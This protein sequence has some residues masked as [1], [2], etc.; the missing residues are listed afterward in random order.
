MRDNAQTVLNADAQHNTVLSIHMYDVFSTPASITDYL[1][2]FQASGWPLV[3]GEFGW[4][5]SPSNVNHEAVLS[6]AVS[7]NL[8]YLG[9]SWAGNTDP[10]LDM[11][12]NFDPNQLTSWGQR[13]FN[14][15]NGI[16][17]TAKEATIYGGGTPTSPPVTTPTS[18]PPTTTPPPSGRTC[19]AAYSI[20]GQW[21]GGFQGE[22]R[23]S[24]GAAAI[25]GW[26][27]TWTFASG[28]A[29][30]QAWNATVTASGSSVTARNVSYN[31]SLAA[32]AAT[33]FGFI[34][35]GN[36]TNSVPALSCAAT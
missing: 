26:T 34:G 10:Y 31:G 4:Q 23:V 6:E 11:T 7:R 33:T 21:Q 8:G 14:G 13:I 30:S 29:V 12:V 25:S 27:V 22:V 15:A 19:T 1:N 24:A 36:G 5:R 3:I 35:S 9:W 16:K 18:P 28:Q 2:R 32:G 17:A 20:V